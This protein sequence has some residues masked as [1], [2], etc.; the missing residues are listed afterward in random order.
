[1]NKGLHRFTV[2]VTCA[3]FLL[4][5]AGALVTSHDA[6]LAAPD[7][8]LSYGQVFP[9]MVGN[10]FWEHGHR[11]VATTVGFLTIILNIWLWLREPRIRVRLLGLFAFVA[12]VAQGLLG[13]LTV[14]MLLPLWVSS[15]H[16]C[17]AQLF[18]CTMVSLSVFTAPGW[19]QKRETIEEPGGWSVRYLCVAA[20]AMTFMQLAL[21]ATLRHSAT[22][23]QHLPTNLLLAHVTGAILVTLILGYTVAATLHRY[24][25]R[26]YLSR[27]AKLA[28]AVLGLQLILGVLTYLARRA[29]P[30][31]PQPLN[32]M[33]SLTVAHVACGA[34]VLALTVILGLRA[35]RLLKTSQTATVRYPNLN[36][37]RS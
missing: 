15:A 17:L 23:D 1:M 37:A 22:W 34:L 36:A 13:G 18:F 19:Q 6:G 21:G 31:D 5:V 30:E 28:A 7:W 26:A 25:G 33:I 35:F 32:P 27:P 2:F 29:S 16:A 24:S 9:K 8:P 20:F 10:L 3:T 14:K 12:V 11:I 4:I